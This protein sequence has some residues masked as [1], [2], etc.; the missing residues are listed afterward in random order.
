MLTFDIFLSLL[1]ESKFF[2]GGGV[3]GSSIV[4]YIY[5]RA[6]QA[7]EIDRKAG[8]LAQSKA[9]SDVAWMKEDV[10]RQIETEAARKLEIEKLYQEEA[11]V[12]HIFFL[13]I[14][15]R[16]LSLCPPLE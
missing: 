1:N 6:L 2:F 12:I 16:S 10:A 14:F 9:Q 5:R 3:K 11:S 15:K 7:E 4:A 13:L 8:L